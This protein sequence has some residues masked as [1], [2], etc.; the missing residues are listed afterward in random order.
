MNVWRKQSVR[1][2]KNGKRSSKGVAGVKPLTVFSKRFYGT[3]ILSDGRKKQIPLSEDRDASETLLRKRQIDEDRDRGLGITPKDRE[4]VQ[5]ISEHVAGYEEFLRS[6][7]STDG[8][9]RQRLARLKAVLTAAKASTVADL[10]GG[11][12][13]RVLASWRETGPKPTRK[14]R[15]RQPISVETS[16]HYVRACR[17][18]SRWLSD[19]ENVDGDVFAVVPV[20]RVLCLETEF[21]R[22]ITAMRREG[23]TLSPL[24]RSAW[25]GQALEVMTRGKSKLRASNGHVSIVA[26]ITSDELSRLVSGSVETT[27]GFANRFL[28]GLVRSTKS[29]PHGGDASVLE[30]FTER[31]TKAVEAAKR[32]QRLRRSAEADALWESVYPSLKNSLCAATERGRPQ[33]MRLAMLYALLDCSPIIELRHLRSA[34]TVWR[35]CE[36]S[37]F[38]LFADQEGGTLATTLRDLIRQQPG[39]MRS[40]LRHSVSHKT[41]TPMFSGALAYLINRGDVVCVPVYESRQADRYYPGVRKTHNGGNG[42]VGDAGSSPNPSSATSPCVPRATMDASEPASPCVL[43]HPLAST[44]AEK[45]TSPT[46]PFPPQ[47]QPVAETMAVDADEFLESLGAT[48]KPATLAELLEWRNAN[49]ANFVRRED[50]RIWVTTETALTPALKSAIH[51]HQSPLAAFVPF[52]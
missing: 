19:P 32:S 6:K 11:A 14:G 30:R 33:V 42:D 27:N 16:N 18:F 12:I 8:Y 51:A 26:H 28:W 40:E 49:G 48:T 34:M 9:I 45:P 50:S 31:L 36:D 15:K 52:A 4:R 47:T 23:S 37:A 22:P 5:P 17:G 41:E 44:E 3:L 21:A 10:D 38:L 24:L 35:F 20:K 2:V 1:Y 46:S 39:I 7:Q 43:L 29:L 25:D 13:G